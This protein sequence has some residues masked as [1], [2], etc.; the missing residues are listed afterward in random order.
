[1]PL[2]D[3]TQ[4]LIRRNLEK[5]HRG[6]RPV[7]VVIGALT[8]EQLAAINAMRME[9]NF[10]PMKA[11]VIFIGK[12]IYK[13]RFVRDGYNFCDIIDQISSA[14]AAEA[15]VL[16]S[17]KMT[18]MQ[19]LSARADRYGNSYIL[20]QIIFECSVRYPRPELS[21]VVPQGDK[22]ARKRKRGSGDLPG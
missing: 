20:D 17:P 13:S 19:S 5:I 10:Q 21:S 8:A 11:E 16:D 14:F 3:A 6:E 22:I 15:K 2:F 9:R 12:H 4:N 18:S 1:M 7:Y